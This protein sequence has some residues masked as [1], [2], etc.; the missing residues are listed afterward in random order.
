MRNK[1]ATA[2]NMQSLSI[3]IAESRSDPF[4]SG[5]RNQFLL[6]EFSD[7]M[8]RIAMPITRS[9]PDHAMLA[10]RTGQEVDRSHIRSLIPE[11]WYSI[12]VRINVLL[13]LIEGAHCRIQAHCLRFHLHGQQF[14][15]DSS[16]IYP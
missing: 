16:G 10:A 1:I 5:F 12:R 11:E 9:F 3:G 14:R 8:V 15:Y 7:A 6:Q 4:R 13:N 2:G